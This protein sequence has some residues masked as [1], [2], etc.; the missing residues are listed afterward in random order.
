[1]NGNKS[2]KICSKNTNSNQSKLDVSKKS[3]GY[4]ARIY[5]K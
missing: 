4:E 5:Y 1:M 3:Q 2:V